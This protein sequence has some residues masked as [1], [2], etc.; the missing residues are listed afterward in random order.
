MTLSRRK[1]GKTWG[2]P[3]P[4]QVYR[5]HIA[6]SFTV[7]YIIEHEENAVKESRNSRDDR[8]RA[9][10][11]VVHAG[12]VRPGAAAPDDGEPAPRR[13]PR[14][15]RLRTHHPRDVGKP[16]YRPRTCATL[17]RP[18]FPCSSWGLCPETRRSRRWRGP[19]G[20]PDTL[21]VR[22]HA[23]SRSSMSVLQTVAGQQPH[24]TGHAR[25]NP[26]LHLP[27]WGESIRPVNNP[28]SDRDM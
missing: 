4:L 3:I 13:R 5:L 10:Q 15:A 8:R 18:T 7:F 22:G 19:G 21:P 23:T 2:I 24:W 17:S 1:Q 26:H 11:G 14:G 27:R 28:S 12:E 6:D 20:A 16:R 25:H 9:Q